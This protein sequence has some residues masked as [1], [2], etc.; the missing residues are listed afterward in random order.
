MRTIPF[1]FEAI[2]ELAPGPKWQS[3]FQRRWPHYRRWFLHQG[4]A[5]RASY[6]TSLRLLREHMPELVPTGG[7]GRRR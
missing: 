2:E 7:A 3:H 4:E 6:A 5:A 1:T